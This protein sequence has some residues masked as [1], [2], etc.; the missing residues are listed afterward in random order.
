MKQKIAILENNILATLSIRKNLTKELIKQ[1]Y[2]VTILTTGSP[3]QFDAAAKEGFTVIDVKS[4]TQNPLSVFRYMKNIKKAMKQTKT[5]ICLTFTIRPA[6]LGNFITRQMNIPTISNIT[7]V[8]PLFE[9]NN[10]VYLFARILYKIALQKTAKI[11]FQNKDDKALFLK[12]QFVKDNI[13]ALIPGSGI[14]HDYFKPIEKKS[15]ND[16]FIFIYI[17]R[18]LKDKG[19]IEY[20]EAARIIKKEFSMVEFQVIGPIWQQNLKENT[21]TAVELQEWINEFIIKYVGEVQDVRSYISNSNC[22]VLPSYREGMSNVLLEASSMERPCIS[23]KVTGCKEI[24]DDEVTGYLCNVAD[25]KDLADKMKLMLAIP[26]EKRIELG[27]NARK[28]VMKEFDKK[29]VIDAYLD[30]LK[31]INK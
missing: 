5:T 18:L 23:T 21:I 11:F 20:I 12:Y 10:L 15:N 14:D 26:E 4:C 13:A 28:K 17:G 6:I 31:Q 29:M 7:G 24:I 25:S 27:K 19:I 16:K 2:E 9:S 30:A 1:G 3:Q 8:G 22:V